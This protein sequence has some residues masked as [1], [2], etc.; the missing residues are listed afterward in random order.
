MQQFAQNKDWFFG[1]SL[2]SR[3]AIGAG[4][5]GAGTLLTALILYL[6]M[7]MV[8]NRLDLALAA[9]T[10]ISRYAALSTQAATFLVVATEAVQTGQ[11]LQTRMQRVL[12]VTDQLRRTFDDLGADVEAAVLSAADLGLDE[13]SRYGTQSLGL[14]RMKALL[15]TTE[16]GLSDATNDRERLRAYIDTFAIGFDPLLSQAVNTERLFRNATLAGIAEIRQFLIATALTIAAVTILAVGWFYFVLIRPQFRRLDR[17]RLAAAQVGEADL[18]VKLPEDRRDE[19][20]ALYSETNRMVEALSQRQNAVDAEWDR[21]NETIEKRTEEL[22]AA[23]DMLADIDEKRRR[24]FADI[25]HE[26][27]TPLTVIMMEAQL[28]KRIG[29]DAGRA[30]ATIESR[31]TRLNRRIDDLLRV[32]RS[33]SGELALDPQ[34]VTLAE[35]IENVSEEVQLEMKT[36][37]MELTVLP[38]P[39]LV[40]RCDPN[41][42]RQVLV[43]LIRNALRHARGGEKIALSARPF[44]DKV[45]IS[46]TD[47]GP[48]VTEHDQSLLFAR[49]QQGSAVQE[50]GFGIGLALSKWVIEAQKGGIKLV[51]PVPRDQALGEACGTQVLVR[52]PLVLE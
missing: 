17:L 38:M 45:E 9:E 22:R 25:S 42:S 24:F 50:Q 33:D 11:P 31:S 27:R 37:E 28:G 49:F 10:R 21:L 34:N 48:G 20:G 26:L 18:T 51:S 40:L 32:A 41:W 5:L 23:N 46:V 44:G 3:L 52:L 12:P 14:A 4:V 35:I 16:R 6:G 15:E 36:A 43:S 29:G 13:Q 47:N 39:D 8:A 30:F 19:I 7:Q 1:R 2:K